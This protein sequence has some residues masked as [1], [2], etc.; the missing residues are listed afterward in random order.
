MNI[1][2]I[3]CEK[4]NGVCPLVDYI[5]EDLIMFEFLP[6][7]CEIPCSNV[8]VEKIVAT[9]PPILFN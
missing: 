8:L 2:E 5:G 4:Y 6:G 7:I 9:I 3:Y 1:G